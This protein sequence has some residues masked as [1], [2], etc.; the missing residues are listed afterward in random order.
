MGRLP[1]CVLRPHKLG[2]LPPER[3]S[4]AARHPPVHL[5]RRTVRGQ[6]RRACEREPGVQ[7]LGVRAERLDDRVRHDARRRVESRDQRLRAVGERREPRRALRR[8]VQRRQLP[9]RG[10]LQHVHGLHDVRRPVEGGHEA[11]RAPEH[12]SAPGAYIPMPASAPSPRTAHI[13]TPSRFHHRTGSSGHGRSA[14][15]P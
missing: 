4:H 11:V 3:G 10:R 12:V 8:H 14:T 1:R 13:L 2:G 7:D 6:L 5:L 15:R 9:L